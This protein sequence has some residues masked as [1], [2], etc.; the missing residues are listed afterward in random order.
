MQ[1][2]YDTSGARLAAVLR[3]SA[4]SGYCVDCLVVKL[5]LPVEE[6]R[7]AAHVLVARPGFSVVEG[8]CYTCGNGRLV[9]R[10]GS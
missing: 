5:D 9:R 3:A 7:D 1:S 8:T 10:H 4:P 2:D 6:L